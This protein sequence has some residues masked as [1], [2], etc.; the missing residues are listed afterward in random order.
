MFIGPKSPFTEANCNAGPVLLMV[1]TDKYISAK[2]QNELHS[3]I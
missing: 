3:C 2:V 1:N